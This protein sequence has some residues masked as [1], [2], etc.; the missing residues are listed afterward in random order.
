MA[1]AH[2]VL[3]RLHA[4]FDAAYAALL[5]IP[6]ASNIYHEALPTEPR[7]AVAVGEKYVIRAGNSL[8]ATTILVEDGPATLVKVVATGAREGFLD[9]FDLG[10][11]RDYT[12]LVLRG[13]AERT[14][15]GYEVI[16]EVD[17]LDAGKAGALWGA[18][19]RG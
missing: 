17:R 10:S 18:G 7:V 6:I 1:L 3:A 9:F 11:S 2:G 5:E 8:S 13:L 16:A 15:A 12:H 4:P 19:S 14:G